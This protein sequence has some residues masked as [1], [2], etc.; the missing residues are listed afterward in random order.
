ME[1]LDI[2]YLTIAVAIAL[3]TIFISITLIYLMFILRD[4]TKIAERVKDIAEKVDTYVTKP[5]LLTKSVLEFLMPFIQ[6]AE[7]KLSKSKKKG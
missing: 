4:V 6:G 1:S 2:L 7:E 3:L 5:I